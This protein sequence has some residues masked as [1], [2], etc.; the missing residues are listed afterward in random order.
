MFR[1]QYCENSSVGKEQIYTII[2]IIYIFFFTKEVSLCRNVLLSV[3]ENLLPVQA[4]VGNVRSVFPQCSGLHSLQ[5]LTASRWKHSQSCT[6]EGGVDG[7]DA[8]SGGDRGGFG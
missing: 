3:T 5:S 6:A 2:I 4:Y 1:S 7:T 8:R